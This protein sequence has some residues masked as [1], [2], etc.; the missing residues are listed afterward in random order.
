MKRSTFVAAILAAVGVMLW[1]PVPR[2][3]RSENYSDCLTTTKRRVAIVMFSTP[4]IVPKYAGMAAKINEAY[5]RRH[6]YSFKHTVVP[7][8]PHDRRAMVWGMV[9]TLREA[10]REAPADR[11]HPDRGDRGDRGV[12][13]VFYIDSDA[14]FNRPDTPLDWL[15]DVDGDVVG[16]SDSPNGLSLINTG[17]LFVRNTPRGRYLLDQWWS[18][19]DDP[20]YAVFPYEQQALEDLARSSHGAGIVVRPAEEFNSVWGAL[21]R[22]KRDT[23]VLHFMAHSD[24]ERTQEFARIVQRDR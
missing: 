3:I 19:R 24:A 8:P 6:G 15:F 21:R 7:I 5:A 18:M 20:K 4:G 1:T 10:L 16:C 13:A 2:H 22:G 14:V 11:G 12:D 17:T 9:H 23:F